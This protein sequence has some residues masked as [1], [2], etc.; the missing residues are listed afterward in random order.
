[1]SVTVDYNKLFIILDHWDDVPMIFDLTNKMSKNNFAWV[2]QNWN[3]YLK[4]H[5]SLDIS[6]Q[7]KG[8]ENILT[9]EHSHIMKQFISKFIDMNV[10]S[11][12][13]IINYDKLYIIWK[14]WGDVPQFHE[15]YQ[16]YRKIPNNCFQWWQTHWNELLS[17]PDTINGNAIHLN[18]LFLW[19]DSIS[20]MELFVLNFL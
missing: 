17:E 5:Y 10:V 13:V 1:M 20:E 12:N 19:F 6:V 9:F 2:R 18:G 15:L 4:E 8:G 14:Q 3:N 7:Y 16:R 11:S